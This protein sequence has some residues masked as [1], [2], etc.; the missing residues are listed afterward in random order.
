MKEEAI[1]VNFS[2]FLDEVEAGIVKCTLE[3]P[4]TNEKSEVTL[5]LSDILQFVTGSPVIPVTGFDRKP[6]IIFSHVGTD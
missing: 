1:A 2:R 3:D 6:K 5:L 4:L